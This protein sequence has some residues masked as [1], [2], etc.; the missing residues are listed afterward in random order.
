M[1]T[2]SGPPPDNRNCSGGPIGLPTLLDKDQT[3]LAQAGGNLYQMGLYAG[4]NEIPKWHEQKGR[5]EAAQVRPLNSLGAPPTLGSVGKIGF[6]TLGFSGTHRASV[7]LLPLLDACQGL[8][9]E[10]V[11]VNGALPGS[12]VDDI[13]LASSAYWAHVMSRLAAENLTPEQVQVAWMQSG[14]STPAGTDPD[15]SIE[16]LVGRWV[17]ALQT[18]KLKFPNLRIL[19]VAGPIFHGYMP[20]GSNKE[21]W[22]FEQNIATQRVLMR[23]IAG[24]AD[25][26][27]LPARGPVVAAWMC[28]GGYCWSDGPTV[29]PDGFAY[30]CPQD[31]APDGVHTSTAGSQKVACLVADD[32]CE[33][34]VGRIALFSTPEPGGTG[35]IPPTQTV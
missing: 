33:R 6:V 11:L 35:S 5:E 16:D 31:V 18:V 14:R 27:Y 15:S 7:E 32:I 3:Y 10:V 28:W 13:A 23:Q 17:G 22:C 2:E 9:P 24:F 21:P 8:K 19:Y 25:L 26:N 12:D 20:L 29:R 34:M 30:V 4:T 1:S